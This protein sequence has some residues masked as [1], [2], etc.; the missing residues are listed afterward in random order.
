MIADGFWFQL[1]KSANLLNPIIQDAWL[2]SSA[3][4]NDR[5]LP[6]CRFVAHR[7]NPHRE[8]QPKR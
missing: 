6:F 8:S 5:I 7:N 4:Q 3:L 1:R 2:D